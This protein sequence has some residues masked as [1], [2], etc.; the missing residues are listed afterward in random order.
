MMHGQTKIKCEKVSCLRL[1]QET[2]SWCLAYWTEWN[3]WTPNIQRMSNKYNSIGHKTY[4]TSHH[5]VK[6]SSYS[7]TIWLL[8]N[9]SP[10]SFIIKPTRL[11]WNSTCFGQ[12]RFLRD[13]QINTHQQQN[14]TSPILVLLESCLQTCMTYTIAECTVNKLPTMDRGTVRNM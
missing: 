3:I 13:Q 4:T 5:N 7:A 2:N 12:F 10:S 1:E 9:I 14:K 6:H 8:S 11:A